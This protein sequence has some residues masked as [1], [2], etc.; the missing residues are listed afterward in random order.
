[1]YYLRDEEEITLTF[2]EQTIHYKITWLSLESPGEILKFE[3]PSFKKKKKTLN[4]TV[5]VFKIE[6]HWS[7]G[8]C[9]HSYK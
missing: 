2:Q 9:D 5:I 1:M 7:R 8:S 4:M 3:P 6:N